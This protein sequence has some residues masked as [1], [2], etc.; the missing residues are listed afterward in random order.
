[1]KRYMLMPD[2][3]TTID[4]WWVEHPRGHWVKFEDLPTP[5]E[6]KTAGLSSISTES[7][8]NMLESAVNEPPVITPE[9][10]MARDIEAYLTELTLDIKKKVLSGVIPILPHKQL[11]TYFK[12][13]RSLTD[14]NLKKS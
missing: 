12:R 1:M 7:I 11:E 9:E 6:T 8:G 14:H 13:L 10:I 2:K 5:V 3:Y 4:K